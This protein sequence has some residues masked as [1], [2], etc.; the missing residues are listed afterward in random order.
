MT[1]Q[2]EALRIA[3]LLEAVPFI[4]FIFDEQ[5]GTEDPG[6]VKEAAAELRRLH[7]L[8]ESQ[9]E[10]RKKNKASAEFVAAVMIGQEKRITTLESALRQAVE[11]VE[12]STVVSANFATRLEYQTASEHR[13]STITASKQALG[14]DK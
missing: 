14:E 8:E 1:Q 13:D 2:P 10:W 5:S 4:G 12:N 11:A 3:D 6:L 7:E 9:K